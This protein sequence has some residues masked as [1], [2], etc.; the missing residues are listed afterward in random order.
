D[1]SAQSAC[2]HYVPYAYPLELTLPDTLIGPDRVVGCLGLG[3]TSFDVI[4]FLTEGRGGAFVKDR[5]SHGLRYIRSNREPAAIVGVSRSGLLP[6]ARPFN[7]KQSDPTVLE[8]KG[9]FLTAATIDRLR[10]Y[11]R[12]PQGQLM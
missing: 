3:L 4:L 8:H 9:R 12:E 1:F 2:A 10:V 7:A 6:S 5:A 11:S